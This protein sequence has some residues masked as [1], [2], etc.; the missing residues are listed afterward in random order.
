MTN[1]LFLMKV[2]TTKEKVCFLHDLVQQAGYL[3]QAS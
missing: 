2:V 3:P 1:F